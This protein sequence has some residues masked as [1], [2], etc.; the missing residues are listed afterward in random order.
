MSEFLEKNNITKRLN[1]IFIDRFEINLFDNELNIGMDDKLLSKKFN[2]KA[3]DLIYLVYD[4]EKE[5]NISVT[6]ED[7]DDIKF[8]TIRNIITVINK[9]L[10]QRKEE[11]I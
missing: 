8:N 10:E 6:D 4:V 9:E 2:L 1:K 7:I 5:F 3:R 11:A